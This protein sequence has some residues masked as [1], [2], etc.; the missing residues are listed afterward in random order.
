M[1]ME[2]SHWYYQQQRWHAPDAAKA[3]VCL[4]P[5]ARLQHTHGPD[6]SNPAYALSVPGNDF[7]TTYTL[8]PRTYEELCHIARVSPRRGEAHLAESRWLHRLHRR[9][10]V[11]LENRASGPR[12]SAVPMAPADEIDIVEHATKTTPTCLTSYL[13]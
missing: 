10:L 2:I 7:Y 12:V 9:G 8:T 5:D 6:G 1:H 11:R 13:T 3:H 4:H